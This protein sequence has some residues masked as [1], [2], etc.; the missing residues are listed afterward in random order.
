LKDVLTDAAW[1]E[2]LKARLYA[3]GR[4]V[5]VDLLG[6]ARQAS[7]ILSDVDE[8]GRLVLLVGNGSLQRIE[9]GELR[10]D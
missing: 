5:S 4:Q 10:T 9:Q 7:G 1:R 3:R 2:K 6:S 8:E